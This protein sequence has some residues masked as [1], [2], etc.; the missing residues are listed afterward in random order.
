MV[1]D[2]QWIIEGPLK[3][4]QIFAIVTRVQ[5]K[6][7]MLTPGSFWWEFFEHVWIRMVPIRRVAQGI[8]GKVSKLWRS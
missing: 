8:Y 2:A 4:E 1:G 5:R 3:R 7:K 6:G